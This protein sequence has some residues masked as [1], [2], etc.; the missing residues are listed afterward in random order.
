MNRMSDIT[1]AN[2]TIRPGPAT[3]VAAGRR[4]RV[5][6]CTHSTI[7]RSTW[8][9]V[10]VY[11]RG[12]AIM[13]GRDIEAFLWLRL[14]G[15]CQL[16]D[17]QGTV[18]ERFDM[19]DVG[20]LDCLTNAP[21]EAAFS[22]II[23]QYGFDL[24]HFQHLG[25]HAASLPII[26]KASGVGTVFSAHDFFLVCS[27]YNL[28]NHDQLFCDI[29]N[30]SVSAC[31]ICLRISEGLPAGAQ[32]TR[33]AFM[34]EVIR[35]IDVFLFGSLQSES[36]TTRIYPEL[37]KRRRVVI[38]VPMPKGTAFETPPIR[39]E[40]EGAP[41]VIAVVGNFLRAKGADA[42][43][44]L[45]EEANPELFQF[46]IIGNA[47]GHYADVLNRWNK[48]NVVYHGRY[49][50]GELGV[51]AD[52]DVSLHLSIWPETYCISLSETW[53]RRLIPIVSDVG[54]LGERVTHGVNGFKV[55]IGDVSAVLDHLELLRAS[56]ATRRAIVANIGAH[57]WTDHGDYAAS[58]IEIYRSVSPRRPLGD[59]GLGLDA[60]QIHLLPHPSWKIPAPP[61][62][63]LDPSRRSNIRLELPPAIQDWSYIQGS[64]VHVDTICG[65]RPEFL[66]ETS[67][68]PA[69]ELHVRGWT[70]VPGVNVAGQIVIALVGEGGGPVIF[71]PASR[72]SRDDIVAIFP[73]APVR[74][75]FEGR[76]ALRGKWCEGHYGVAIVNGFGD[77]ASFCL[78]GLVVEIKDSHVVGVLL[79]PPSNAKALT[80]F[81][82][83]SRQTGEEDDIALTRL[84]FDRDAWA[85]DRAMAYCIDLLEACGGEDAK[86]AD[87]AAR[88]FNIRGWGF[89]HRSGLAGLLYIG[90]VDLESGARTFYPAVRRV[91][92]DVGRYHFDAPLCC[93]FE[94]QLALPR[95]W[96]AG[97][98]ACVL[99]NTVNGAASYQFTGLSLTLRDGG[100]SEVVKRDLNQIEV[101]VMEYHLR[102]AHIERPIV[103]G[104]AA[105]IRISEV[106]AIEPRSED[107][108]TARQVVR[109]KAL[110]T[111]RKAP[112]A[113]TR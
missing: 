73:R 99:V 36:L 30:K 93:G 12:L 2:F 6:M 32:G 86:A 28:L 103:Q 104:D 59:A 84:P 81:Y 106:P 97:Q 48:P 16:I 78:T 35:S 37:A 113:A 63:I 105:E 49:A 11:Q 13:L 68:N 89:V 22:S 54:A 75:G 46:H 44:S 94:E 69:P 38:G 109:H 58:L 34:V 65:V 19:P 47:E 39:S 4:L 91:R 26:A 33:R 5:L 57:L 102:E 79:D 29:G 51:I 90:L 21:E 61:R 66:R 17:S 80:T 95:S 96:G 67:F 8:G 92:G 10:E 83:V 101:K 77:R 9:G 50:P 3:S 74:S 88:A 56:P 108:E 41:L 70:F 85:T 107:R 43:I 82:R 25:H 62:H 1:R 23:S 55:A 15:Q 60:G 40:K 20:W 112:R 53:Q 110:R 7:H 76:V 87:G 14:D 31:D 71:F 72:D 18:L 64:E 27:R 45:I 52:A 42:V 100:I 98:F 24:V 111:S